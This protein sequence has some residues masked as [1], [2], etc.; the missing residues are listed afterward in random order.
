MSDLNQIATQRKKYLSPSFSLSYETPLHIVKGQAQYLYTS[1]GD[2]YLDAVNNIQHVGHCHPVVVQAAQKQYEVLNTNTRYLD[3][4]IVNYAKALTNHLPKGLDVCYFTNSGSESNDLALRLAR[5]ATGSMETIV[6]DGAY[7]GHV[8]SLI[9]VSPYK[10]NAKGG[11]GPPDFVYTVPMPDAYRGKYRGNNA[12]KEYLNELKNIL[13]QLKKNNKKISAFIV[14]P[15]MGCGGQ[16]I[17]PKNFLKEAF[18]LVRTTGGICIA[19]EVQ[20]GFG[21]MGTK[22]W[23]F[24]TENV[25]P[26]IVTMGKSMGNG[27]PLSAV[28]TTKKIADLFDNGM[29]YFNSFGGNPVS[30]AVG[31][32]VLNVIKD[33]ELQKNALDVGIYL[34]ERLNDLKEQFPIIGDVRGRGLF[35]GVELVK[36]ENLLPA[37]TEAHS[38]VNQMKENNILLSIDGPDH[39][40]IKIKPPLVFN[41]E[42]ADEL[43]LTFS[44]VLSN[45]ANGF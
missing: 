15:I 4:T 7:H 32:A 11:T 29:E 38:I 19:D 2:R 42:N 39:N 9:E 36:N 30:C 26:D 43:V 5:T 37:K 28:V 44:K 35:L 17:L 14:E 8:S 23:G 27:H 3:A 12:G 33:E 1:N 16:L 20:I 40:V 41:K 10:H 21:R 22:F 45:I 31:H 25:V 13:E 6:L 34:K 18:D 24:E